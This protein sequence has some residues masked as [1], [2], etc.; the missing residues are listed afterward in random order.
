M[1]YYLVDGKGIDTLQLLEKS[2]PSNLNENDV[3]VDVQAWSLNY[4]DLM[5][6]KGQYRS[7]DLMLPP[8]IP[9]S[10]MAGIVK[11]VGKNVTEFKSGDRVL[12]APFRHYPAGTLRSSWARTFVGGMGVDGVLAE[13]VA[14]PADALV[15]IPEYL[16]FKEAATFTIAGLTAWS[17]LVT[18]GRTL[19]GEW[20]LL[21]GTGGVSIFAA[22]L[23][24]AIGARTIMTTSSDEKADFVK[25]T[26]GVT[27]TVNYRDA[28]WA[29]QVKEITQGAGVDVVVDTAG[30]DVL[31]QTLAICNYGARVGVIGVLSGQDST[32]HIRDLLT[33]Q[34]QIRGIYME[35]TQE[36]RA[37]MRAVEVLKLKPVID[38]AFPFTQ[39][40]EAYRYLESQKHVGKVVI[41][42]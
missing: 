18:H 36:L 35:S 29:D 3:L 13:Q 25:K 31:A 9:V 17:A 16:D 42:L 4:R 1:K 40:K 37:L 22:Q 38:K 8:F 6:A 41:T 39:A 32:I 14:Y 15:K 27:A 23:A 21:H 30:G 19:P 33:H 34:V 11:S 7:L 26:F 12:N 24:H 5:V 10:D 2:S 20:V 28:N